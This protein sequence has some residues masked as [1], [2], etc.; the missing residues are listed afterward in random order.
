MTDWAIVLSAFSVIF[1]LNKRL[2]KS[3]GK[4]IIMMILIVV[5]E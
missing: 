2:I 3:S 1:Y 5:K 4:Q